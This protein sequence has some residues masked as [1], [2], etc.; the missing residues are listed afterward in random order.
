MANEREERGLQRLDLERMLPMEL[1]PLSEAERTEIQKKL[2]EQDLEI[3]G[4]ILRKYGK[5]KLAEH[6]LAVGIDTVQRLDNERKIYSKPMSGETGSGKYDLH[7]RGGDTKFIVP[8]L[9]VIGATIVGALF[10]MSL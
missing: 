9:V 1:G 4:E 5:S 6:D 3:R 8:I 10:V 7:V 2:K